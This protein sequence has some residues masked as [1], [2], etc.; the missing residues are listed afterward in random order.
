MNNLFV[1]RHVVNYDKLLEMKADA[2]ELKDAKVTSA[3]GG[4]VNKE[5]RSTKL[6]EA[7]IP[8]AYPEVCNQ[9]LDMILMWPTRKVKQEF[10]VNEFNY[11]IYNEG[12]HFKRHKDLIDKP[13]KAKRAFTTSTL[14]SQ[15]DDF[16]GGDLIVFDEEDNAINT[17]LEVGETVFFLPTTYHQVTP[18]TKGT[19]EVLVAWFYE[20]GDLL[21]HQNRI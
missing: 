14:I 20:K 3:N 4:I 11:L 2:S 15:S 6:K 16:E 10:V 21:I 18:V 5:S 13:G 9:L 12:D 8:S 1:K 7:I 17:S 19:R